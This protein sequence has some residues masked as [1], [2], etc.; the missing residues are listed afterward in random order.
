MT[1]IG[2]S[3]RIGG[4]CVL[5]VWAIIVLTAVHGSTGANELLRR[6]IEQ[7]SE[8]RADPYRWVAASVIAATVAASVVRRSS[9]SATGVL[10]ITAMAFAGLA[11]ATR[12]TYDNTRV[13]YPT[14][15]G[16]PAELAELAAASPNG[17][18]AG[19]WATFIAAEEFIGGDVLVLPSGSADI[20]GVFI[21]YLT[22]LSGATIEEED[23][24]FDVV[25]GDP[26][27]AGAPV[28]D[29]PLNADWHLTIIGDGDRFVV[30]ESPGQIFIVAQP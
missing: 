22:T 15:A 2:G 23:Y 18:I 1:A 29:Q 12:A 19:Q 20:S 14:S 26:E 17:T 21:P 16:G 3:R 6:G 10:A 25:P 7:V 30:Y 5:V 9:R 24:P 11:G 4:I 13:A 8:Q 28:L 27:V